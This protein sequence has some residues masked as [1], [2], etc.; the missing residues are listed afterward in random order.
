M[1]KELRLLTVEEALKHIAEQGSLLIKLLG[2]LINYL[3]TE[4]FP[5]IF[6]LLIKIFTAVVKIL[7][8]MIL[9][10]LISLKMKKLNK[11]K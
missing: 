11:L 2:N 1:T 7:L 6:K 5:T 10:L 3:I 9:I 4:A 8:L